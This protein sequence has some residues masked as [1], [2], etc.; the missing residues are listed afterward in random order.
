MK[1]F[2]LI[3][4]RQA[5]GLS[6]EMAAKRLNISAPHLCDIENGKKSPSLVLALKMAKLYGEDV[7]KLFEEDYREIF[8][9]RELASS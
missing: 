3:H 8:F 1:R 2:R 6:Q 7:T 4:M 9:P 5:K